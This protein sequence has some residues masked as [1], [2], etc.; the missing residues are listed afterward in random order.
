MADGILADLEAERAVL[1][2]ILV[3]PELVHQAEATLRP[4]HFERP[5]HRAVFSAL[6]TLAASGSGIDVI[7][8][9]EQLAADDRLAEAGGVPYLGGLLDG[10]PRASSVDGWARIV[11]EKARRRAALTL[12]ERLRQQAHAPDVET[13]ELLDR[14]HA[15]LMRLMD[16]GDQAV[17]TLDEVLP[18]TVKGLEEFATNGTGITGVPT[19]IP[20]L[21]R[22]TGGLKP[23]RLWVIGARPGRG[24]SSLCAQIAVHAAKRHYRVLV[25][26]MEMP[27]EDVV[28]RMLLAEAD[29]ERWD[30]RKSDLA[31]GKVLA[32]FGRLKGLPIAF[33]GREAPTLAQMRASARHEKSSRGLDLVIV[34]YLQRATLD[35]HTVKSSG[36]WAAVGEIAKGLKSMSR[37]LGVPVIAA[38]QLDAHAE[39]KRPTLANLQQAQ[40]VISAEADAIMFLHPD[41]PEKW[42]ER[43]FPLM[44][45]LVDKHRQGAL[46]A[47]QLSFEKRTTTFKAMASPAQESAAREA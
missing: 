11:R 29:V 30:L 19:G 14:H 36:Q 22:L 23:G 32:S 39:E 9:R 44:W 6:L 41:E 17:R 35:P 7:T 13:D 33:D 18:V 28:E 25:I 5:A 38:S 37:S 47:I 34:D 31:W 45:L 27:P 43:E 12:A 46:K 24:K 2:S 20:D 42:K 8:L 10:V 21:D 15:A 16:S 26:G 3:N 1:G 4:E 40:S